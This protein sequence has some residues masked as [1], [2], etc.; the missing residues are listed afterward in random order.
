ADFA[1]ITPN[2][3]S[4]TVNIT[5]NDVP[6]VVITESGTTDVIEGGA[7]DTYDVVLLGAPTQ[8]V[9]ITLTSVGA[10][11]TLPA[12]LTF[13]P[14]NYN[15]PQTITV[16]AVDDGIYEGSHTDT[17]THTL[18]SLDLNYN[19]F[20]AGSVTVFIGD[21]ISELILNGSFE[22]PGATAK[23]AQNWKGSSLTS[24]DRRIC[25]PS[26]AFE[27]SCAF[28]FNFSGPLVVGRKLKQV[29]AAPAW[30]FPGE[31]L[32]LNAQVSTNGFTTGAKM[33]IKVIYDDATVEKVQVAIPAGTY[34]YSPITTSLTLSKRVTK[35]IV[36]FKVGSAVGRVWIDDVSFTLR[37]ADFSR[38]IEA[39]GTGDS[40]RRRHREE[41]TARAVEANQ[42]VAKSILNLDPPDHTRL[43]RLVTLA[44]T[45]SAIER[46]RPRVRELVD[47]ALERAAERGEMEL[48][49][50][51][52]FPM[53][54]Q[55]ISDLLG[56]PTERADE[57][58][59][60]S[61]VLTQSLE[62]T[63]TEA[64][65]RLADHAA[66]QFVAYIVDV[67]EHRRRH[68]G[69][70]LLSALI[71][72]E[73]AGDRMSNAELISF[74]LLLYVA[75]HETTVNLI[76]NGT[77]ALLR[78]PGELVRWRDD[79]SLDAVAVDELLRYDGPVQ[80]TVRVPMKPV[81]YGEVTVEPGETVMTV[82]GAANHDPAVFDDPHTLRLGRANANRHLAFAAGI[83]YC[84]GSSL[85][86]LEATE[87]ISRLIR[88]FP[89][90]SLGGEPGWRD[91]LT[92][93][94]VDRLPLTLG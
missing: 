1:A 43:R 69:D 17:I 67:I 45:P 70:D 38:D 39:N 16:Q 54:F 60:W 89:D 53:P 81:S 28:Q 62:P 41:R 71:Q 63:T 80:L 74:T 24:L 3:I 37:S 4:V 55:V 25:N 76:G 2:S 86:K 90:V 15:V 65:L 18:T 44:F 10:Q 49:D 5:D 11:L 79:P 51:L 94:G 29:T 58:R 13:T 20:P 14:A 88:R 85:A 26:K 19:G 84:L 82:L 59:E 32:T 36:M 46:L 8:D 48:I 23:E 77:L 21:G 30:G 34:P 75:G 57:L 66:S 9:T 64:E 52:A 61:Q 68:L 92:I 27:G 42:E 7:T 78:N 31:T 87:A 93:R 12:P 50:D 73:E 33:R 47:A 83:H 22:T 6:G 91:R 40:V 56:M 72:A 35:A